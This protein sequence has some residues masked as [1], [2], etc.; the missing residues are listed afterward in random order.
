MPVQF[1]NPVTRAFEVNRGMNM[2][3]L[4]DPATEEFLHLSGS[5]TTR[6]ETYAWIGFKHQARALRAKAIAAGQPWPFRAVRRH[7]TT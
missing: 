7:D 4:R 1:A 3:R 2:I 5:G 6:D